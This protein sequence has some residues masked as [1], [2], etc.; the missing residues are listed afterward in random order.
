LALLSALRLNEQLAPWSNALGPTELAAGL[1]AAKVL[2][3]R[4]SSCALS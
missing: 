4:A 3:A 2:L 1:L